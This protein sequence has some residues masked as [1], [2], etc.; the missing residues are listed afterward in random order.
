MM[1]N[2]FLAALLILAL[3][4][5][6]HFGLPWWSLAITAGL[7]GAWLVKSAWQA[8]AAGVLGGSMLWIIAAWLQDSANASVLSGKVGLLFQ[9][10]S[11]TQLLWLTGLIGGLIAGLG[12]LTG[13]LGK[14]LL[15]KP[16]R[17]G[18]LQEKRR[19]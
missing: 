17:R 6:S 4:Q 9:G 11:S 14:D 1:K 10:A 16:A 18:Y 19:R 3:G 12:A 2:T 13:K 5:L 7:V 15:M 8:F